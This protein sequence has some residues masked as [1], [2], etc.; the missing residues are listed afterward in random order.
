MSKNTLLRFK[1][2]LLIATLILMV[3]C[4]K[5]E[6][7]NTI[8]YSYS[9]SGDLDYFAEQLPKKHYGFNNIMNQDDFRDEV[10]LLKSKVDT[11]DDI[12][13]TLEL[14]KILASMGVA[15]TLTPIQFE[16]LPLMLELF[17]DGL[18]IVGIDAS[19]EEFLEREI[20]AINGIHMEDIYERLRPFISYENEYWL[21]K[22]LPGF[23]VQPDVLRYIN[24]IGSLDQIDLELANGEVI[25][26]SDQVPATEMIYSSIYSDLTY[27]KNSNKYY[28]FEIL[29]ENILYIQYNKCKVD[30]DLPFQT[31]V[32]QVS[33]TLEENQIKTIVV[34]L[35][36]NTGG[37]SA[38]IDPLITMLKNHADKRI[39]GAMS[40]RTYSSGRFAVRD[41]INNFDVELIGEP[42]GGAPKSYGNTNFF[43]LP[44]SKNKIY[45]CTKY[46]NLMDSDLDYFEP[47]IRLEYNASD[48]FEGKD[49]VLDYILMENR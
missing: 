5:E 6:Q 29:Q 8:E 17:D 12:S 43:V 30:N 3:S 28:W 19:K 23:I 37:N 18:F 48:I 15:H 35:R 1:F 21:K 46:F 33:N 25:A 32:D 26:F 10:I 47:D 40:R 38:I 14:Q 2:V 27:L 44:Y 31:F 49:L 13:I 34:D 42:T 22:Q 11:L 39:Y 36:L 20:V 7:K 24:V 45:Y 4:E 16:S 41:L 9:W